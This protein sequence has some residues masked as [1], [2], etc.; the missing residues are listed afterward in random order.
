M[1]REI[2][3]LKVAEPQ[4]IKKYRE[5]FAERMGGVVQDFLDHH[6]PVRSI[7]GGFAASS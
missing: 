6:H 4:R 3:L 7:K 1:L 2:F 5:L